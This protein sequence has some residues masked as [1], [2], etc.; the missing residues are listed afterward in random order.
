MTRHGPHVTRM[1][2]LLNAVLAVIA[3]SA[4]TPGTDLARMEQRLATLERLLRSSPDG[5]T[6]VPMPFEVVDGSGRP[7]FRVAAGGASGLV[8]I[9]RAADGAGMVNILNGSGLPVIQIGS[10]QGGSGSVVLSDEKGKPRAGIV[11]KGGVSILNDNGAEIA[12]MYQSRGHGRFTVWE[13]ET[14]VA[15]LMADSS[16]GGTGTIY[17]RE[18]GGKLLAAMGSDPDGGGGLAMVADKKGSP[19]AAL[20]G[21][22]AVSIR[23]EAGNEIANLYQTNGHGRLTIWEGDNAV[24]QLASDETKGGYLR[25]TDGAGQ[26]AAAILGQKRVFGIA[27]SQGQTVAD[28]KVGPTGAGLFQ[29]WAPGGKIAL[30]LIGR[31]PDN[32][33]GIVQVSNGKSAIMSMMASSSG[34]GFWQLNDAGGTPMI[35]AGV[36]TDGLG[37]IRA[38]PLYKCNVTVGMVKRQPDCI[39]GRIVP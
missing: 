11:G 28:I 34:S 13:G 4:A 25:I 24:A 20:S 7:V 31:A 33:G 21:K 23:N 12:S 29:A 18:P 36:T 10:Q 27:N 26:V 2:L 37:M 3:F 15:Q 14:T 16:S 30:A 5:M 1:S 6:Q 39:L 8:N 32:E 38:G 35:E 22:G 19:R 17:L 9:S